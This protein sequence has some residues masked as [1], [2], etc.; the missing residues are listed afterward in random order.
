M[1]GIKLNF[2]SLLI[3]NWRDNT[4]VIIILINGS[5]NG[6]RTFRRNH[7]FSSY[8]MGDEWSV[9]IFKLFGKFYLCSICSQDLNE[10]SLA[11][12]PQMFAVA[13]MLA[14]LSVL[15]EIL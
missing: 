13:R 1:L 14:F 3:Y 11:R 7:V 2:L 5:E 10:C 12:A 9:K 8:V 6:F 15:L 4:I